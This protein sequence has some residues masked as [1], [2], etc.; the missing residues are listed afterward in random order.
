MLPPC[1]FFHI[2]LSVNI[3]IYLFIYLLFYF[4]GPHPQ[5]MEVPRLA[6]ESELQL[7]ASATAT[8]TQDPSRC[9]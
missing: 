8:A 6:V 9:L 3:F 7:L 4:L 5:H 1:D 2:C